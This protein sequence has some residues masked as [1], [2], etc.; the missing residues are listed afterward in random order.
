MSE[1]RML[2]RI[3]APKREELTCWRKLHNEEISKTVLY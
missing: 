1:N 2:A 3:L